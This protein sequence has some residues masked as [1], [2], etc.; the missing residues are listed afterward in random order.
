[1]CI[2]IY[3]LDPEKFLSALGIAWQAALKTTAVKLKLVTDIDVLLIVEKELQ[4]YYAMQ[5][6]D[7]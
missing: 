3:E 6:I 5:F 7:M 1:M 4:Q 2:I